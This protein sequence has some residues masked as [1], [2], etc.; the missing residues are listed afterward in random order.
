MGKEGV[1]TNWRPGC[2]DAAAGSAHPQASSLVDYEDGEQNTEVGMP[3]G[4]F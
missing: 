1:W 2:R 3:V 4:P